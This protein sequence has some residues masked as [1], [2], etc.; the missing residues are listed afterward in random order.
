MALLRLY[1]GN[2]HPQINLSVNGIAFMIICLVIRQVKKILKKS[3]MEMGLDHG[4]DNI[5]FMFY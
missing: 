2:H 3:S 5:S 1:K 4:L